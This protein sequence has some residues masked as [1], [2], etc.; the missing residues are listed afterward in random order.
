[1]KKK[2]GDLTDREIVK[3]CDKIEYCG[4]DNCLLFATIKCRNFDNK[5]L[6]QEIEVE[7]E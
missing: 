2:I 4:E 5:K 3:I 6:N 1:M 7:E